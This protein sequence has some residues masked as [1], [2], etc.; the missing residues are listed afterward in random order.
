MG[1]DAKVNFT[2]RF[3]RALIRVL[4]YGIIV[5][6]ALGLLSGAFSI[7]DP[8]L[9]NNATDPELGEPPKSRLEYIVM[10]GVYGVVTLVGFVIIRKVK[11]K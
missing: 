5:I 11:V 4:A 10:T 3:G 8:D 1:T 7:L 6:G 2:G 9:A